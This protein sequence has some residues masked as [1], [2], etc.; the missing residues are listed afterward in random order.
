MFCPSFLINLN[1]YIYICIYS[2]LWSRLSFAPVHRQKHNE[3][4]QLGVM[5]YRCIHKP[6][7]VQFGL[8]FFIQEVMSIWKKNK[9]FLC[10][11]KPLPR[12]WG[13]PKNGK[14]Q[15]KLAGSEVYR[16]PTAGLGRRVRAALE[17]VWNSLIR[18]GS[19]AGKKAMDHTEQGWLWGLGDKEGDC[20]C[21]IEGNCKHWMWNGDLEGLLCIKQHS[22][23]CVQLTNLFLQGKASRARFS[24]QRRSHGCQRNI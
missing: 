4:H 23:T 3:L 20:C 9:S 15:S 1:T 17:P 10:C 2:I 22:L 6:S 7:S 19:P 24:P 14:E 8:V 11:D 16:I 12:K 18:Q 13:G 21:V 5:L